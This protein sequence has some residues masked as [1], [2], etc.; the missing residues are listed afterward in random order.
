[1]S[2]TEEAAATE[3]TAEKKEMNP[4]GRAM[5]LQERFRALKDEIATLKEEAAEVR[6]K[7]KDAGD[8]NTP[9]IKALKRR[10][11]YVVNRPKEAR[12]ELAA[13]A[14]ERKELTQPEAE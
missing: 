14:K 7:L 4:R 9:E 12:L 2:S 8:G 11:I 10:K 1:M 13:V 3:A 5:Y 6:E